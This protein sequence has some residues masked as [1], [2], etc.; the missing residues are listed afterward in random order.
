MTTY[1]I[2]GANRGIGLELVRQLSK[3]RDTTIL[4]TAR[5]PEKTLDLARLVRE[6]L[7]LDVANPRSVDDLAGRVGERPIDVLINNAGVGGEAKDIKDMTQEELARV[8]TI[9]AFGPMLVTRALLRN[10]RA[11]TRRTVL[12]IT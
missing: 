7:P 3:R 11:G 2:T 4:A 5:E 9:N 8:F 6:V 12:P 1:L 10:M